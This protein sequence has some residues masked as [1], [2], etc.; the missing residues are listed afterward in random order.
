MGLLLNA[1]KTK[2]IV[3]DE[4]RETKEGFKLDDDEL[5]EVNSF[6]YSGSTINSKGDSTEEIKRRIGM[7]RGTTTKIVK[8]WKSKAVSTRLK[9]RLIDIILFP[10]TSYGSESWA[11]KK[12]DDKK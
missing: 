10:V 2:I 4:N 8:I 3:V 7:V 9:L 5:E 6:V 11:L 12:N 1:K